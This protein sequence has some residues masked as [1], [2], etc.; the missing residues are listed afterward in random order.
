[1]S[2]KSTGAEKVRWDLSCL[3]AGL[4]DPAFERDIERWIAL[5][6]RFYSR[7]RGRLK[8]TLK[9]AIRDYTVLDALGTT[10][11]HFLWLQQTT[12]ADD[13]KIKAKFAD[14]QKRMSVADADWITFFEHELVALSNRAI[15]EQAAKSALVTKHLP[16]IEDVR[17]FKPHLLTENV[18]AA[19]T[20]REQ[21]GPQSWTKF[22]SEIEA[23]LRFPW[24]EEK[25]T[26]TEMLD[27]LK[28][29]QSAEERARA[30]KT[31]NDGFSGFF[32]KYAAE[33]LTQIVGIREAEDR[34][35]GFRHPMESCNLSN[36]I[37]DVVVEALH[38]AVLE[39][40]GPL[41]RRY[42]RL[43][44]AHLGMPTLAWSDRNAPLPFADTAVIPWKN[45]VK[46]VTRAYASF[47][48]TL[49]EIVKDLINK[50]RV[51]APAM[52]GKHAGAYNS[53]WC[54]PDGK[55]IS[56]VFLNYL[57]T[58]DDVMTFAHELGH[59]VHGLLAGEAQGEL[60]LHVPMPY[61]ETASVFGEMTAF[62]FLRNE[63]AAAGDDKSLLALLMGKIE[64]ILNTTVRQIGFSNFERRI[65]G[66]DGRTLTRKP[67]A[68]LSVSD[69]TT[70]WLET[71]YEL[72]GQPGEVFTYENAENFWA[73][74]SHF[75]SPFYVYAYAFGELLTQS[76][77]A[78]RPKF[79]KKF[80]PLYLDLLRAGG[81]K[82]IQELLL[83]FEL[84]PEN[85]AFWENGIRVSLEQ[86][87]GEA[88][89]LSK[90]L[91]IAVR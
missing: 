36:Q 56:F 12:A 44:A 14:V 55:P 77:Y 23:D 42:F 9:D 21:F 61:A 4:D 84:D 5:A 68:T 22:F 20:R 38:T 1:M 41:C 87:L 81:T 28:T 60:M 24:N 40:A 15:R 16:F 30:Q 74:I 27:I 69:L 72:Y 13:P 48:P 8:T 45:A 46:T 75:H 43:K 63:I 7:H 76:L 80:E 31:V 57:G 85:P 51:D 79:G 54:K 3:Y 19:L 83:P 35:R 10:I 47:S 53:S 33:T 71:T 52:P 50:R 64:D 65:H 82:N 59:A 6:N 17:R 2:S 49:A 25:R 18:E 62:N 29:S 34:D 66:H 89:T 91:G 90:K 11:T 73:Y 58:T 78:A 39:H 26:I 32:A 88:E 37:P 86:M 70:H 67:T